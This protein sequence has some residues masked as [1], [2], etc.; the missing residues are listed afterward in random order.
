MCLLKLLYFEK[1]QVLRYIR[2]AYFLE[3]VLP[4]RLYLKLEFAFP[5]IPRLLF[6]YTIHFIFQIIERSI[7]NMNESINKIIDQKELQ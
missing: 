3:F 6:E 5:S 2:M 7:N 1:I 4:S